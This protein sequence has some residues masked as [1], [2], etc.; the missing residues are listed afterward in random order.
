VPIVLVGAAV[1]GA[2]DFRRRRQQ[3]RQMHDFREGAKAESVDFTSR[4]KETLV[5]E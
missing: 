1:L 4:D 2:T 5:S 3:A